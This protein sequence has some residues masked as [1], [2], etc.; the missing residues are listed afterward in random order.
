VLENI[1]LDFPLDRIKGKQSWTPL[2]ISAAGG[3]PN[4]VSL[5]LRNGASFEQYSSALEASFRYRPRKPMIPK[6]KNL[7]K[8]AHSNPNIN[9][10]Y[11]SEET[12][13][14]QTDDI[15]RLW[16]FSV[17]NETKE[18]VDVHKLKHEM[19][20]NVLPDTLMCAWEVETVVEQGQ[21]DNDVWDP[22]LLRHI[23]AITGLDGEYEALSVDEYMTREWGAIGIELLD[24]IVKGLRFS[25]G[26]SYLKRMYT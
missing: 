13:F 16:H 5:L 25:T 15:L 14:Q 20:T 1:G 12:R 26:S 17:E 10:N 4:V 19:P 6:T 3:W 9:I 23:V 21:T 24:A 7:H 2:E 8:R 22:D 18:F 11:V